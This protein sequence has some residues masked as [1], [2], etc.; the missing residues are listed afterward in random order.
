MSGNSPEK[1]LMRIGTT[2]VRGPGSGADG[3]GT[4]TFVGSGVRLI[5]AD[6]DAAKVGVRKSGE[7]DISSCD[8]Q[9]IVSEKIITEK[10]VKASLGIT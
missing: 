9:D 3:V 10:I 7:G 1:G 4:G 2:S 5:T 8:E 6:G